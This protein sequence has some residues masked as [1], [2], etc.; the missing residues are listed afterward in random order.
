LRRR[1][2]LPLLI[3]A[4]A[5]AVPATASAHGLV[6]RS[7]LPIPEWLFGWA[8]AIVLVISFVALA[9]LWPKPRMEGESSF[10]PIPGGAL[11]GSRAVEVVC[12]ALGVALLAVVLLAGYV[13]S[14]VALDNFA[15]T[16]ILITF[17]VGLVFASAIFGD[18]FKAF[19]PWRAIGRVLP[20]QGLRT[21]PE[22]L[23][24][25]PA[26][27]GLLLFTWIEL[28]SGWG[29]DPAL[30]VTAALGYTILTLVAQVVF[31]VETWTR[32]GETFAVYF[33]LFSRIAP[34]ETR[35]RVVGV[36][37]PLSGLPH[38]DPRPGTVALLSVMIGTVT[39]DGLSQ[40]RLW[41][42]LAVDLTDVVTSLGI[43]ITEAPRIVSTIG[44]LL[45]VA[46]VALFYRA[47]VAGAHSVGG[48]ISSERLRRAFVHSLVPIAMVYVAAHYL[49][50][51]LF[52]GQAIRYLASDPFGQ[53]WDLFGTASAAI[54][55]S[56]LS[57][58][59]AWYAQVA[60]VVLGHVAALVLAHDRALV[61]YDDAKLAVRSQYWMLAIMVGFTTLAL[62]LLAQ[63]GG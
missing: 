53:G 9:A 3:A 45:G 47:G 22:K 16:F 25:W 27:A 19:S 56:L 34:F 1:T 40:G 32:Y 4:T 54:D 38:L 28:C 57:Q 23:G 17:W 50:F 44:L 11:L 55:Y 5:L 12:G 20:S 36:R 26:A 49:T 58:N 14:G 37:P 52:E 33:N 62:W 13:G 41:K 24:R 21:Y 61:L 43:P 31:G 7:N 59:G 29:E 2:L 51:L 42:D 39:F 6:Q 60:F 30:L 48:D 35:D 63:A 8:A 15:P 10:K 18:V 46:I